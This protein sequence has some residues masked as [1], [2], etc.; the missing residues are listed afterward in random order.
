MAVWPHM[1]PEVSRDKCQ[2]PPRVSRFN[3]LRQWLKCRH[4][5]LRIVIATKL[6]IV[7]GPVPSEVTNTHIRNLDHH[8]EH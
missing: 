4:H 6:A 5:L 1:A 8:A 2:Q 7:A 3:C